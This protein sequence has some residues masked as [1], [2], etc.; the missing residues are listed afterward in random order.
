MT[1]THRKPTNNYMWRTIDLLTA[2]MIGVASGVAFYGYSLLIKALRPSMAFFPPL[3]GLFAG[4]WVIPGAIAMLIIRKPGAALIAMLLGASIEAALGSH[5]G[6]TVFVSGTLVASGFEIIG[7]ITKYRF[8]HFKHIVAAALIS[9]VLQWGWEQ[10]AFYG[11]WQIQY[12]LA[13]LGFFLISAILI[14]A[15]PAPKIVQ[16]LAKAGALNSF[17]PG[18]EYASKR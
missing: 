1:N 4:G 8:P 15:I 10:I 11:H 3:E 18:K 2:V 17:P 16:A 5:F 9:A 13:H 14:L 12:R 7:A 6:Y